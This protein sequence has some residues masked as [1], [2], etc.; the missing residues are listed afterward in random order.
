MFIILAFIIYILFAK[1]SFHCVLL[2]GRCG[3]YWETNFSICVWGIFL[4]LHVEYIPY[5]MHS[6]LLCSTL[7]YTVKVGDHITTTKNA[8]EWRLCAYCLG[9]IVI[10]YGH[11]KVDFQQVAITPMGAIFRVYHQK[12]NSKVVSLIH[13]MC[14]LVQFWMKHLLL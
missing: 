5:D 7:K 8:M 6:V 2:K 4:R 1:K 12:V 3:I 10:G 11:I 9:H 14:C 13:G